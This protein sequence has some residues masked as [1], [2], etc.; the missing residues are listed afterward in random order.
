MKVTINT[1]SGQAHTGDLPAESTVADAIIAFDIP[2]ETTGLAAIDG[3]LIPAE[4]VLSDG[5]VV[6][7]FPVIIG[8]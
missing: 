5:D 4:Y 2:R 6:E 3:K 7:V 1:T 8:G